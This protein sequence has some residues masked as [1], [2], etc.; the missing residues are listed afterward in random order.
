M[1]GWGGPGPPFLKKGVGVGSKL[2]IDFESRSRVDLP[3]TGVHV[4][5]DDPSTEILCMGYAFDD[6]A[7]SL[8]T[9]EH[10]LP[11]RIRHHVE[12]WGTVV[13]HNAAFEIEIWNALIKT[14]VLAPEQC[15]CVMMM[16]YAMALPGSLEKASLAVGIGHQKD[17]RGHRIMMRLSKPTSSGEY[18]NDPGK[19]LSL[20]EY[21][22]KDVEAQRELYKRVLKLTPAEKSLWVLDQ[23]INR[24]GIPVDLKSA[25][26][27]VEVIEEEKKRLNSEINRVTGNAVASCSSV[28]QLTNWISLD[29]NIPLEGVAKEEVTELLARTDLPKDVRDALLIRRE[30]A[31]SSTSKLISMVRGAGP[32]SRVRGTMQ[33]HGATTGRW[34]GRRIQIQNFPRMKAKPKKVEEIFDLLN[35]HLSPKEI[36]DGISMLYGATMS[37]ISDVLRAFIKA[38]E[39][40]S[41][42][43]ADFSS[44]EARVL[45][46]L[47]N[48]KR[49]LD[50]FRGDG[51]VYEAAAASIYRIP[52]EQVTDAQRQIGKVACIAEGQLVLTDRG[53]VAIEKLPLDCRVWDGLEWV[54]HDGPIYKGEKE[55]IEWDG[56]V[57]TEDHEVWAQDGRNLSFGE[58]ARQQIFLLST[59]L[60]GKEI[61]ICSSHISRDNLEIRNGST[62]AQSDGPIPEGSLRGLWS[63]EGSLLRQ[64]YPGENLGVSVVQPNNPPPIQVAAKARNCNAVS[65]QQSKRPGLQ[66]LRS[67]GNSLRVFLRPRG[68]SLDSE[69]PGT[70]PRGKTAADGNRSD[71][72]LQGIRP[73]KSQVCFEGGELYQSSMHAVGSFWEKES[74]GDSRRPCFSFF[75]P[76]NKVFGSHDQEALSVPDPARNSSQIQNRV[77]RKTKRR[78][79]DILNAGPRNRF[80]VSGKLVHNCLALGFAGG[81]G[82]FQKMATVYGV[83]VTDSQAEAIKVKWREAHPSIVRYWAD[84]ESAAMSA[85]RHP[86]DTFSVGEGNRKV[87]YKMSGSFLFCRLPSK[88]V[89]C[90]PYPKIEMNEAPWGDMVPGLVYKTEDQVI[91][92]WGNTKA[93]R[94]ILVENI[95]Q[96]VARDFLTEA[97]QRLEANDFP[98]TFHVHDEIVCERPKGQEDFDR[99][100]HIMK[101]VPDWARDFPMDASGWVGERYRK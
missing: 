83:D 91:R 5:A 31:K 51:K 9:P 79:W 95:V 27:A 47:A 81:K 68:M 87:S 32:D 69:E 67:A 75:I 46:W 62:R 33:A 88:R 4:Y 24:R 36:A 82:A 38:P 72:Q 43:C 76:R 23:T 60:G 8:W 14:P 52:V 100:I 99:F 16:C 6:E 92:E 37:T 45:A 22:L 97:M 93:W 84:L 19:F 28:S 44:I 65:V 41:F 2:F 73:R 15:E 57:A 1:G 42:L 63:D 21:C 61:R 12:N 53:L 3:K 39:G 18:D 71:R 89:L 56:L 54:A 11:E 86:G 59:G 101:M 7:V 49:I 34:A 50:V 70:S 29:K 58:C 13:A 55:T 74:P 78:V 25:I 98:I 85:V 17:M 40:A 80:T 96:A 66:K 48:E 26:K 20:Y 94:G 64:S 10:P 77:F 35:S 30:F 90:Y